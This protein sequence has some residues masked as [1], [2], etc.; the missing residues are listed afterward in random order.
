MLPKSERALHD[1]A[2]PPEEGV[3]LSL[4]GQFLAI[5][6][7]ELRLV[8][9]GVD[10]ANAT[11]GANVQHTPRFRCVMRKPEGALRGWTRACQSAR[12]PIKHPGQSDTTE[13]GAQLAQEM[14]ARDWVSV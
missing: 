9:I 14:A 10:M 7:G 3:D 11:A 6:P 5:E 13:T 8:I 12:F 2:R 1:A 4:V